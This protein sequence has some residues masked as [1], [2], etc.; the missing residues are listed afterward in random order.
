M[1]RAVGKRLSGYRNGFH[2]NQ[3]RAHPPSQ[4]ALEVHLSNIAIYRLDK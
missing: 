4:E 2:S 3:L 1:P